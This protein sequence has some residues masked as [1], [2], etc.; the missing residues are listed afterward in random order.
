MAAAAGLTV[1]PHMS[2]GGLGYVDVVHYASFTP[3]IGPFM[4]FK[5]NTDIPI[6][7][8]SSSL[9]CENGIVRAPNGIGWGVKIDPDY[10]KAAEIVS[11][12]S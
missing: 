6:E 7:C 11:K 9:R 5:G 2:G 1:V 4:E 12:I 10:I 8:D 3:N